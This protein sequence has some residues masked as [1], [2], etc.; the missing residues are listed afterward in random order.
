MVDFLSVRYVEKG[1]EIE[2]S[3]SPF[4][5][6]DLTKLI[7]SDANIVI[8]NLYVYNYAD[9]A[10]NDKGY[11]EDD[12]IG[13]TTSMESFLRFL[14]SLDEYRIYKMIFV[15]KFQMYRVCIDE[16]LVNITFSENKDYLQK[17]LSLFLLSEI[18]PIINTI[19]SNIGKYVC[20]TDTSNPVFISSS[21]LD[22]CEYYSK[23]LGRN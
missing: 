17:I 12:F 5:F 10:S 21:Y 22:V 19:T 9:I 18:E 11:T 8:E 2:I 15:D 14:E 3:I 7:G 16:E 4:S 13:K 23:S 20:F 6:N 1:T